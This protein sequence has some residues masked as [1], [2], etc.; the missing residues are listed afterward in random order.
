MALPLEQR[1]VPVG[2]R[3]GEC[4]ARRAELRRAGAA[5]QDEGGKPDLRHLVGCE[6]RLGRDPE[7]ARDGVGGSHAVRPLRLPTKMLD[8]RIGQ[9]NQMPVRGDEERFPLPGVEE[10]VEFV[11]ETGR[12]QLHNLPAGRF[13]EHQP[14]DAVGQGRRAERE[15]PTAGAAVHVHRR[16]HIVRD[17]LNNGG[18]VLALPDPVVLRMVPA[19]SPSTPVDR[20]NRKVLPEVWEQHLPPRVVSKQ[21]MHQHQRRALTAAEPADLSA[22]TGYDVVDGRGRDGHGGAPSVDACCWQCPSPTM[23]RHQ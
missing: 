18:D 23:R 9:A 12:Q 14:P 22:V 17:S 21:A 10:R 11:E 7:L 1:E 8:V 6:E 2:E 20:V 5:D 4:L 15:A 19:R 13:E 16:S 3:R